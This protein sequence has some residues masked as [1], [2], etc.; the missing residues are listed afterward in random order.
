MPISKSKK[1]AEEV[2]SEPAVIQFCPHRPYR[3]LRADM[4]FYS[5]PKGLIEVRNARLVV[6]EC[7]DPRQTH[8]P[9]ECMPT[10]MRYQPG[11]VVGWE[12]NGKLLWETCYYRNAETGQVER[13]W[14]QAVEF[15]GPVVAEG[16][17]AGAT[18]E[19][20]AR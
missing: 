20:S 6:L 16:V 18:R 15:I 12:L 17:E 11:Q 1:P 5:D 13:A 3:V 4:P 19:A 7:I 9:I 8:R 14:A 2:P 10:R